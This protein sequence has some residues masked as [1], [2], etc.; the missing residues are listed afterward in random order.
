MSTLLIASI[1]ITSIELTLVWNNVSG[2][3][4][5]SSAGQSIPLVLGVSIFV[6]VLWRFFGAWIVSP[7]KRRV[8]HFPRD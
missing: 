4:E 5:V 6:F 3:Y 1:G 2:V 7:V 8:H